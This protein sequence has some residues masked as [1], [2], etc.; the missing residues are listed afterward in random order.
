MFTDEERF[1]GGL[2]GGAR[3]RDKADAF[4]SQFRPLLEHYISKGK[5]HRQISETLN[6]N[7]IKSYRGGQW[8]RTQVQRLV[9][10]LKLS[11]SGKR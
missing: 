9:T 10:R 8:H 6:A 11:G 7:G 5:S 3:A 4:A 2:R 1:Q